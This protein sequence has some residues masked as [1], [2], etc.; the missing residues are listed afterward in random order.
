MNGRSPTRSASAPAT[1]AQTNS[2]TVQGSSIRPAS[3]GPWPSPVWR[4]WA[5]KKTAPNSD[6]NVKKIAALPAE[7][8]RERKK[9]IGSIGSRARSSH[10]TKAATSSDPAASAATTSTLP[11][12]A[13]LPRTRPQTRPSA[14]PVTS[15]R[16]GTS[17][18]C[19]D[20]SSRRSG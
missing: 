6:A 7:N 19:R 11:Q 5:K 13:A 8:A 1:G 18:P 15:A 12:P 16:P 3:S 9:R 2:V 4:N 17:P 14:P 20:R 10:A